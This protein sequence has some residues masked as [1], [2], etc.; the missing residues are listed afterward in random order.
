MFCLSYVLVWL[1]V[2]NLFKPNYCLCFMIVVGIQR[3]FLSSLWRANAGYSNG[4]SIL[5]VAN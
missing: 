2:L 3:G 4:L 1:F 5:S